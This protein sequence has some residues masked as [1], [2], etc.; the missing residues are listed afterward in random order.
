MADSDTTDGE[1]ALTGESNGSIKRRGALS[2]LGTALA[3]LAVGSASGQEGRQGGN[4]P[5][6]DWT[7]DVDANGHSL[8]DLN[9]LEA[10]QLTNSAFHDR[11]TWST[12]TLTLEVGSDFPTL[13]EC[14]DAVPLVPYASVEIDIPSGTDLSSED[15]VVPQ[16]VLGTGTVEGRGYE[17]KISITGDQDDPSNCPVGSIVVS[18]VNGGIVSVDGVEFQRANPHSNDANGFSAF[19]THQARI[20][21]CAFAGGQNGVMSYGSNLEIHQVDFGDGVLEGDAISVKHN[22]FVQEQRAGPEPPT[23]G[24]VP[25]HAYVP[26]SGWITTV[27]ETNVPSTLTGDAGLIDY[28]TGRGGLV[29]TE[30]WGDQSIMRFLG[31]YQWEGDVHQVENGKGFVTHSPDGTPYR[32]RVDD[33]GEV[34]TEE[35]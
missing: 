15:V 10:E 34:V 17:H 4:Q 23:S 18:G 11:P 5:W 8:T 30:L 1:S 16:T 21:N 33:D 20:H 12:E 19:Y 3:G 29:T 25:G 28:S 24:N 9:E 13:Q 27:R 22:G 32:I 31:S 35:L 14:V 6:Y 2:L 26:T 7:A